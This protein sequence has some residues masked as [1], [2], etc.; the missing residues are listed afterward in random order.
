MSAGHIFEQH[1]QPTTTTG[2]FAPWLCS[3]ADKLAQEGTRYLEERGVLGREDVDP[4]AVGHTIPSFKNLPA[5]FLSSDIDCLF[6]M[7]VCYN[8]EEDSIGHLFWQ[9]I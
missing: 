4:V 1:W 8:E 5:H 2:R 9:G 6:G 7:T 3:S